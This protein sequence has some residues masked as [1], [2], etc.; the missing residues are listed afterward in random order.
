M[1][2]AGVREGSKVNVPA[3]KPPSVDSS[4]HRLALLA[5]LAPA[6]VLVGHALTYLI[7]LPDPARRAAVL[8]AS[9]HAWWAVGAPTSAAL[10]GGGITLVIAC[11]LRSEGSGRQ[12]RREFSRWLRPRLA[13]SQLLLFTALEAIERVVAGHALSDPRH[14]E[15]VA[16]G[17]IAQLI[18][19]FIVTEL[20][21][22]LALT[23]DVMCAHTAQPNALPLL[24]SVVAFASRLE[25]HEHGPGRTFRARAP[26]LPR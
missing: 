12:S 10:A 19:A 21:W 16:H 26:P 4:L 23:L 17:V 14:H 15:I 13:S 8:A 1:S 3:P 22:C 18:V 11:L 7:V 6:G 25:P 24:D 9:G 5:L 20:C 2:A